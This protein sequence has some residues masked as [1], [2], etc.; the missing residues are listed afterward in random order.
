MQQDDTVDLPQLT[1]NN[2]RTDGKFEN[3]LVLCATTQ[4]C[5]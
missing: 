1:K 5:Y 4:L 2:I 3:K